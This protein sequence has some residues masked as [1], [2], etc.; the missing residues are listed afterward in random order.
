MLVRLPAEIEIE[1]KEKK[2]VKD[3]S[4]L[5]VRRTLRSTIEFETFS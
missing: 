5:C 4:F 2:V 1:E 3:V